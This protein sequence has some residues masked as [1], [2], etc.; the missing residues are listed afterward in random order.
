MERVMRIGE[1]YRYPQTKDRESKMV[2]GL[3]NYSYIVDLPGHPLPLL[4]GGINPIGRIKGPEG[5]R[6]PAVLISSSPHKIGTSDTPWQ[7]FF[8][9]DNGHIRYFG[10]NKSPGKDRAGQ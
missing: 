9:P 3:A 5:N 2:D 10:D 6:T 8:D 1:I 7:D 4:E